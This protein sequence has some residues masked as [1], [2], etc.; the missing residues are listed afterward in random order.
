MAKPTPPP[1]P[2]DH[3]KIL[4]GLGQ[5]VLATDLELH[6]TYWNPAAEAAFG[7]SEAE[8]LGQHVLDLCVPEYSRSLSDDIVATLFAGQAWSGGFTVRRKS[9][10]TFTAHVTASGLRNDDGDLT[11]LVALASNIGQML[12]PLLS[13]SHEAAVVTGVYGVVRFASPGVERVLGWTDSDLAGQSL[14]NLVHPEDQASVE[15]CVQASLEPLTPSP[16][17]EFRLITVDGGWTWVEGLVAD[18]RDDPSVLGLVWTLRDTSERRA[19][20][21]QMTDAALHDPLTGMPN[22]TLLTDRIEVAT[23]RRDPHGALLFIDLD[24]FKQ[25]NDDLGHAAGDALL[26]TVA[27]RLGHTVRPEDTCG[28]WAGDEFLVLNESLGTMQ[29]AAV[30]AE[31]LAEAIAAP[32]EIADRV[33]TP[34][35]SIGVAMLHEGT[36]PQQVIRL[37]DEAMYRVKDQHHAERAL[38]NGSLKTPSR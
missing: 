28:R 6:V 12:R 20:L 34:Q 3:A 31:R 9:G 38:L 24:D 23:A 11:G 21:E 19:A 8:V 16:P 35:A 27:D 37:A 14:F 10:E 22:R 4:D 36:G 2:E 7:W 13:R 29:E 26:K 25:V 18:L 33:L 32:V 15:D 1:S 5:P 17:V 30:F